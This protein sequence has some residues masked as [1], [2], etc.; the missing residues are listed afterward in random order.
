MHC[1]TA[2]IQVKTSP[3]QGI[4]RC[5]GCAD[6]VV[7]SNG[8][9]GKNTSLAHDNRTKQEQL[10]MLTHP[11]KKSPKATRKQLQY[12]AAYEHNQSTR[13]CSFMRNM[14]V[15]TCSQV[16]RTLP[17]DAISEVDLTICFLSEEQ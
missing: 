5:F 11:S 17:W 13:C 10:N 7:R 3:R 1:E 15:T 9:M 4:R 8:L 16:F 6:V 14:G 2:Y 12:F